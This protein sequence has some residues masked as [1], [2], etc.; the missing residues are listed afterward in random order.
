MN[1]STLAQKSSFY[2]KLYDSDKDYVHVNI[3]Y[4]T[5]G[6]Q[7]LGKTRIEDLDRLLVVY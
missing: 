4:N 6:Y 5:F 1:E 2:S 7:H 3:I